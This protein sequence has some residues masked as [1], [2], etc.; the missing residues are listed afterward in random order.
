MTILMIHINWDLSCVICI[1][2]TPTYSLLANVNEIDIHYSKKLEEQT[3]VIRFFSLVLLGILVFPGETS[4]SH[5]TR[6]LT[7]QEHLFRLATPKI[8]SLLTRTEKFLCQ[9]F[10]PL[11]FWSSVYS[12]DIH[13]SSIKRHH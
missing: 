4:T 12:K 9:K 10:V 6:F 3:F 11:I 1:D 2:C 5:N 7:K 13:D 8:S